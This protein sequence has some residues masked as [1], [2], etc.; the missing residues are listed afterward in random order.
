ML[1]STLSP[2]RSGIPGDRLITAVIA[3]FAEHLRKPTRFAALY[4]YALG[5]PFALS[6][7]SR[8]VAS[9][10][11]AKRS[12][13]YP[14]NAIDQGLGLTRLEIRHQQRCILQPL[15]ASNYKERLSQRLT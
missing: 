11:Q 7:P 5:L 2:R 12:P 8:P 15:D 9:G 4:L 3:A 10:K 14:T 1:S 6:A 13:D